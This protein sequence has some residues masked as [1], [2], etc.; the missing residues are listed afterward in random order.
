MEIEYLIRLIVAAICGALIGLER[1]KRQKSAGLRTHIIVAIAS[2]LMMIVSKYGFFDVLVHEGVSVDVS[3][4]AAGVVSA[5]G[6]IG[7]GVIFLKRDTLVG[8]TTAAGLWATVG[9]GIAIGAGM[10][11]TGIFTTLFILLLQ[12][13]MHWKKLRVV[14]S[15]A[16][17][18][19]VNIT[20]HDITLADL[21]ER[22]EKKGLFLRN[23][24]LSRSKE[25]DF[26]LK[27]SIVFSKR[28]SMDEIIEEMKHNE[29]FESIDLFTLN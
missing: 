5:I 1:E 25:D 28:E 23:I 14:S 8:L 17:N 12:L 2:S 6:F 16:G 18:I 19:T 27:A 13:I 11:V 10:Y 26:I 21:R 15:V 3:R 22:L 7:G 20:K 29:I 24:S 9:V 4:V